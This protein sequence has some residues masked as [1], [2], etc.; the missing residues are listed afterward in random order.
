MKTGISR[1][2]L[3][4]V[5]ASGSALAQQAAE[6]ALSQPRAMAAAESNATAFTDGEIRKI[7]KETR[8]VTIRHGAITNLGMPPMTMGYS[9]KN[10]GQL[11]DLQPMQRVEFQVTYDGNDYSITEIKAE[12]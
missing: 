5:L 7:N 12:R 2:A 8:K 1:I 9:V 3:L 10:K 6:T 4:A 11:A